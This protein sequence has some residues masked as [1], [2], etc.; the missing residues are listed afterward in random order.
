MNKTLYGLMLACLLSMPWTRSTAQSVK[1]G[2]DSLATV[3]QFVSNAK[4]ILD[5]LT[6]L[7][8]ARLRIGFLEK[9]VQVREHQRDSLATQL[10]Q[11]YTNTG[12]Q[13]TSQID[14]KGTISQ[15]RQENR[16]NQLEIWLLRIGL[17]LSIYLH[18]R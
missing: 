16:S 10:Q 12:Q 7:H 8:F 17:G 14:D 5:S 13:I 4:P 9:Q 6:A 18:F 3:R 1:V 15:Q 11:C 2:I